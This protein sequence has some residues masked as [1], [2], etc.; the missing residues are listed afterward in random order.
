MAV[1]KP[2]GCERCALAYMCESRV[3]FGDIL[4]LFRQCHDVCEQSGLF[5]KN[6]IMKIDQ[7]GVDF[8]QLSLDTATIARKVSSMWLDLALVLFKNI[9][10][11]E[12]PREMLQLLGS[13]AGELAMCFRTISGWARE[14]SGRIHDAIGSSVREAEVFK[15]EYSIAQE[16]AEGI[17]KEMQTNLSKAQKRY[18]KALGEKKLW[19]FALLMSCRNPVAIIVTSIG[20]I[21]AWKKTITARELE[22]KA[23][24]ELATAATQMAECKD[25]NA[26]AQVRYSTLMNNCIHFTCVYM[27]HAEQ[28]CTQ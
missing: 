10:D 19:N 18:E 6:T 12:D 11:V 28:L 20:S 21:I 24:E 7:C 9:D 15:R 27:I 16:R 4:F 14:I 5:Q 3:A 26:K 17:E 25:E 23:D 13:Q 1:S 2:T 22:R 8:R